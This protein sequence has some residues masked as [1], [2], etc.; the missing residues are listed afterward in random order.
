MAGWSS[1]GRAGTLGLCN[2]AD[3]GVGRD[4]VGDDKGLGLFLRA[5]RAVSYGWCTS[6]NSVL[7]GSEDCR[8]HIDLR[9]V[10]LVFSTAVNV[11]VEVLISLANDCQGRNHNDGEF[12]EHFISF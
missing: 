6:D 10:G 4:G 2:R 1:H 7:L 5:F 11:L 8:G 12:A 3:G 9:I